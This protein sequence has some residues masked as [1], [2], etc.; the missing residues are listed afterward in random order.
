M[1]DTRSLP[2]KM[3][4]TTGS[5]T[6]STTATTGSRLAEVTR[7]L[8]LLQ[9][10]TT[11]L[12]Q[13]L[14]ICRLRTTGRRLQAIRT[15]RHR[16]GARAMERRPQATHHLAAI[17]IS[18]AIHR[19][20]DIQVRVRTRLRRTATT[21]VGRRRQGRHLMVATRMALTR[22]RGHTRRPLVHIRQPLVFHLGIRP[23]AATRR[24]VRIRQW[25]V[26][27]RCHLR[28]LRGAAAARGSEAEVAAGAEEAMEAAALERTRE[29]E[30]VKTMT[31]RPSGS[32]N[33]SGSGTAISLIPS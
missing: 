16:W 13:D 2:G 4:R 11:R 20:V 21:R 5:I 15:R 9:A 12:K 7:S 6:T 23:Q 22:H 10:R 8:K 19:Q 3:T 29:S 30:A 25:V 27:H 33:G 14:A 32:R 17:P 18:A 28:R 24:W 31:E 1:A 26:A